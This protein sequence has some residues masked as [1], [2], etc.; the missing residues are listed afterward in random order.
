M[1]KCTSKLIKLLALTSV[2]SLS[3]TGCAGGSNTSS[4]NT[5]NTQ[6]TSS[7]KTKV[8]VWSKNSHDLEYMNKKI[9]EFNQTN[10]D[11]IEI[12]YVVQSS[13]D[14]VN[15]LTMSASSG[16]SPDV[17][18]NTTINLKEFVDAGIIQP[19]NEY[20][21]DEYKEINEVDS[22]IFEG[23]NALEG[24]IYYVPTGMRSGTRLIY[25]KDLF[26]AAGVEVPTT[27][28]EVV[29]VAKVITENGD[30]VSYGTIFPGLSNPLERWLEGSAQMSGITPY[31]YVNGKFDFSGY[32][33]FIEAVRQMFE[34][35]SVFPGSSSMQI[36]P[37]RT[38]F[39][40]GNVGFYGN[41]SQEAGVLTTQ[42]PAECE[43][44]VAELPTLD[45][46]VKGALLSTPSI[47]WFMSGKTEK[48][49]AAWKVIEYFGSEDFV[50]GYIEAGYCLP[51]SEHIANIVDKSKLG[52]LADF[53]LKDYETVYPT[54]PQVTPAGES[55]AS[56][57]WNAC[58]PS[59]ADI[60]ATI[61][62]LNKTYNEALEA[63]IKAGKVKRVII[64]NYDPLHPNDGTI[65]YLDK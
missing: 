63:D 48:A 65:T 13:S 11:N 7:E 15:M 46:E 23:Y 20:F 25:N 32:K 59:G 26:E 51:I 43:W 16:Q 38:Q 55:Y 40:A 21:T 39:A 35:E 9:E 27:L 41:A 57:L 14:Y 47:G 1:K 49:E 36:D 29:E 45:G 58:L 54:Y 50:K 18:V 33:P 17:F 19:L 24:D 4:Q 37:V 30:G 10:Q 61:E 5:A 8:L 62:T 34:D 60:D 22:V 53:E 12:E 64:E 44:G 42:F 6:G 56:A 28:N 52:R 3:L 31:D 2:F